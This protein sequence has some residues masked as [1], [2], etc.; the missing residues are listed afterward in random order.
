MNGLASLLGYKTGGNPLLDY[1][2][3]NRSALLGLGAGIAGGG[4]DFGKALG[5]G[6]QL[7]GQGQLQDAQRAELAQKQA[8]DT[9]RSNWVK[10]NFPQFAGLPSSDALDMAKVAQKDTTAADPADVATYKFY[11]NQELKAGR[12]PKS[13]ADWY[14]GSRQTSKAGLGQ[15]IYGKNRKTGEYMPFEPMTDGTLISLSDKNADPRDFIFDPGTVASDRAAGTAFGTAQ[16]TQQYSFPKAAQDIETEL[17]NIDAL[18]ANQT[19]MDQSFGNVGGFNIGGIGFPNQW[20]PTIPNTPKAGFQTQLAQVAG[21][22]FLTAYAQLRGAGAITEVEGQAAK[23]A[24]ARLN[25]AQSK[26]DFVKALGDL[27]A[28]LIKGYHTMSTQTAG[29]PYQSNG[30]T[31]PPLAGKNYVYNPATGELE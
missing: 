31:P 29:G 23:E 27:K 3:S 10:A 24:M 4:P 12:N 18:L 7:A 26:E 11:A 17:G 15:P 22:N 16:G 9:L 28:I 20:A 14:A 2:G 13:F 25:T 1:I 5:N 6:L 19:G 21:E 30:Y 8:E